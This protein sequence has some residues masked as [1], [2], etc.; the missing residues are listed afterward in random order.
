M[1]VLR[2]GHYNDMTMM[3]D[4]PLK[5]IDY[6]GVAASYNERYKSGAYGPEGIASK[7]LNLIHETGCRKSP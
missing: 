7:L 1:L 6:D 2:T 5:A 3:Q 4:K